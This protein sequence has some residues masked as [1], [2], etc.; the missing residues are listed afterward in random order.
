LF[1]AVNGGRERRGDPPGRPDGMAIF[2]VAKASLATM[3]ER[4]QLF[5]VM[6]INGYRQFGWVSD[7]YENYR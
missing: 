1:K 6:I 2:P 7:F 3:R 5:L 4:R